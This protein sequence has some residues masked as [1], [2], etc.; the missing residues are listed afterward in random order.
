M[1]AQSV[2]REFDRRRKVIARKFHLSHYQEKLL[3]PTFIEQI[4]ACKDNSA[5]R[6]L[7]GRGQVK[8]G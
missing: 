3:T 6:I 5:R 1:K 7:L 2:Y 4:E 8:H